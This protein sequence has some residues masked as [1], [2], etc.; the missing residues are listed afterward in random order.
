MLVGSLWVSPAIRGRGYGAALMHRAHRYA[1]EKS[2][3]RAFLR[4]GSYEARPFYEKLGYGVYAELK[5]HP[6]APHV[7]YF[8]NC[9]LDLESRAQPRRTDL[10]IAMDPYPSS[11]AAH[12]IREGIIAH[13]HAAIGLPETSWSPHNVFLRTEHGE[14]VGG[15]L[16]NIWS[17]WLYLD[18]VWI[19]R[20]IRGRGYASRMVT[21]AEQ[22][23]V[24]R[25][26]SDAFLGTF[27]FQARPLYEK[28]GYH[29]FGEQKDYP[30]G[31][32]HYHLTKR[33]RG[34]R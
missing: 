32:S 24:E 10:P 18:Y 28:L 11:E 19:D 12:A 25:G 22:S 5:D 7:R 3:T 4:T 8:M 26:C 1:I 15:A 31:H 20:P 34:T 30:Q 29:V 23:A 13:A 27:S 6:V 14:I 17:E 33:L 21:A 16:G 2:C 9:P